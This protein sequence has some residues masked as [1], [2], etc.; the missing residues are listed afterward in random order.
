M[1]KKIQLERKQLMPKKFVILLWQL[2]FLRVVV[3]VKYLENSAEQS[4]RLELRWWQEMA[5]VNLKL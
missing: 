2:E 3:A 4:R 1:N 5:L